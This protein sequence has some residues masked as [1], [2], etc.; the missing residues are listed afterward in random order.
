M[1]AKNTNVR[2]IRLT[3]KEVQAI[4]NAIYSHIDAFGVR[5]RPDQEDVQDFRAL[6]RVLKKLEGK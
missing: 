3:P 1:K 5:K 2:Q 4:K 6:D